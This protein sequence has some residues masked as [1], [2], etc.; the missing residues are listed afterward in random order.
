MCN[1]DSKCNKEGLRK[2]EEGLG[3]TKI[4][5]RL[6]ITKRKADIAVQ[7]GRELRAAGL[8]DPYIE[9]KKAPS[10]AS[11]WRKLHSRS[12]ARHGLSGEDGNAI[13]QSGR[14][15]RLTQVLR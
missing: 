9:L 10:N 12:K 5:K 1:T 4:G 2:E 8:S 14:A 13:E 6:G 3:L 15:D 11:R 7:Y